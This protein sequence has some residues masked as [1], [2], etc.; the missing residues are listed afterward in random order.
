MNLADPVELKLLQ[1]VYPCRECAVEKRAFVSEFNEARPGYFYKFPPLIGVA[2]KVKLL[3]VGYNPRRTTNLAIHNFAMA[4]FQNFGTLSNNFD[5]HG[6]RYIGSLKS[7]PDHE[8]HYEL[9]DDIVQ[10][11][12]AKPFEDVAVVTEMY[13]CASEDGQRLQTKNSPCAKRYLM[14]TIRIADPSYLVTFGVGLPRFFARFV[15]GIRADVLHVPF[16]SKRSTPEATMKAAV[17]WAVDSLIAL[18]AGKQPPQ[19][20]WRWPTSD[21][22]LP[23]GIMRYP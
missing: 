12:F 23:Q 18:E 10:R 17:D 22:T 6:Q 19:K 8:E 14:R 20:M 7:A 3:L 2:G 11:V 13:L 21:A 5:H 1:D 9:H 4:T 15:S 16:P